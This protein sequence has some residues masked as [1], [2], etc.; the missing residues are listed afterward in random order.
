MPQV[1]KLAV[2]REREGNTSRRPIP[3]GVRLPPKPPK[4]P[5]W[6]RWFPSDDPDRSTENQR[7]RT[8]ASDKWKATVAIFAPLG[9]LAEAD[10]DTL[11]DLC[12]LQARLDEGEA[13]LSR[14]GLVVRGAHG[15]VKNPLIPALHAWRA[16]YW[17][18]SRD[19][20]MTPLSRDRLNPR[21]DPG[22]GDNDFDV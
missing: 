20:G 2:V 22:D 16:A 5:D 21:E 17:T 10:T 9:I 15:R 12:T 8:V 4:E 14:E 18:A 7:C 19:F 3:Q 6:A 1:A 13:Q 11:I